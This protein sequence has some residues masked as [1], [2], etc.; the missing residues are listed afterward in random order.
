MPR[1]ENGDYNNYDDFTSNEVLKKKKQKVFYN[2]E[3]KYQKNSVI[4]S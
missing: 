1:T 4:N 2:G 3:K